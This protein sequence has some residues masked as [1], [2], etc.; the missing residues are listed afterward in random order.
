MR[1]NSLPTM[2]KQ[3][4]YGGRS[5]VYTDEITP[6]VLDPN[7]P[8]TTQFC[9]HS[10]LLSEVPVFILLDHIYILWYN[11][12]ISAWCTCH[13]PSCIQRPSQAV[14]VGFPNMESVFEEWAAN[15]NVMWSESSVFKPSFVYIYIYMYLYL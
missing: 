12:I 7:S 8:D 6:Q 9:F 2:Q 11:R 3:N 1:C 4:K 13:I 15:E 5:W 10:Q 14:V